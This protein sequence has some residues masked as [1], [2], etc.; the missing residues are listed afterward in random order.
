MLTVLE[1]ITK[2]TEYLEKKGI[3]SPRI[4]AE[5][6]L[7]HVL[8]CKRLNLYLSFDRPLTESEIKEYRELLKRRS[9]FEPLQYITGNIEFYGLQF[10]V[11]PRAL[12]P[13]PETEILIDTIL[14]CVSRESKLCLLDIGTGS[15]N[16]AI[17][18]AKNLNAAKI[19]GTDISSKALELAK[20]NS[21][22]NGVKNMVEFYQMDILDTMKFDDNQFDIIVSNPPYISKSE[23][24]DLAP[25][26]NRY[27]PKF[28]LTDDADGLTFYKVISDKSRQLLKKDGKLFFEL[29][30]GQS[31]NVKRIMEEIGYSQIKIVKDLSNI[32][33]V[34][35]GEMN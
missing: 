23:F 34:I 12:I 11:D 4:N 31:N 18:L 26:L 2:S 21:E 33:R 6:L 15:G 16:I 7:S 24:P 13:R 19:V 3:E 35:H 25:E 14:K 30:L 17:S 32:D 20:E 9:G 5:L 22:K 29:G 28:A 8:N 10:K 27:E 1:A